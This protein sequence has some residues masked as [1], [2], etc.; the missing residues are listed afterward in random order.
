[1]VVVAVLADRRQRARCRQR[2]QHRIGRGDGGIGRDV[3]PV[4][5]QAGHAIAE[6]HVVGVDRDVAAGRDGRTAHRHVSGQIGLWRRHRDIK[7]IARGQRHVANKIDDEIG[8][9]VAVGVAR[10][11][12]D[13][14]RTIE[15]RTQ[16]ASNATESRGANEVEN[17]ENA[18]DAIASIAAEVDAVDSRCEIGDAIM[19]AARQPAVR[20]R[21]IRTCRA[22][23]AGQ[24]VDPAAADQPVASSAADQGVAAAAAR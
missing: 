5:R 13:P 11:H 15:C 4:G 12:G 20:Q 3:D 1:M 22:A 21:R 18:V 7:Q 9:P 10:Q 2:R 17:I 14:E 19:L 23:P 6:V 16:L 24:R 8:N